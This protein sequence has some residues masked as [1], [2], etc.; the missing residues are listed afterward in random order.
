MALLLTTSI[1]TKSSANTDFGVIDL[2]QVTVQL[3]NVYVKIEDISG[4]KN[5]LITFVSF[6]NKTITGSKRYAFVPDMNGD[7]FIKQAYLHLK[8]LPEF[9]DATDC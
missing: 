5:Q 3:D 8:T 2:G 9:S 7:N 4:N 6:N 1:D